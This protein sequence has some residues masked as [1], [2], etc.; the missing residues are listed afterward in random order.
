LLGVS[1]GHFDAR[2]GNEYI[3]MDTDEETAF[4]REVGEAI[5]RCAAELDGGSE[6]L[7]EECERLDVE[8][9]RVWLRNCKKGKS[10]GNPTRW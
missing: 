7:E 6:K 10:G 2:E 3:A 4:V 8:V 1:F 5:L 9:H